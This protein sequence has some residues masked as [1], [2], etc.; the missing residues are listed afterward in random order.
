MGRF[1]LG[2]TVILLFPKD[3]MTWDQA[4]TSGTATRLGESLGSLAPNSA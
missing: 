3:A 2:S 4:Y 1:K